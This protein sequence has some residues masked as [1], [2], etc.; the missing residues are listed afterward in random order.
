[1]KLKSQTILCVDDE[2]SNLALLR[3]TLKDSYH[4]VFALNGPEALEAME[5]HHPDLVLLD[6]DMPDMS[7]YEVCRR[8]KAMPATENTPVIFVTACSQEA[9]EAAGF[10][11]G[12]VDYITKPVSTVIVQARVQ[13]HLSLVALPLLEQ[14]YSAAIF[15]LGEAG[16]YHDTDT[17]SHI[18][19]M[20]GYSKA[21]AEAA[22]WSPER[23][24]LLELAAPMHDTGKIGIPDAVLKK[25]G[26]FE[27][28]EWE[29]MKTHCRIGY[30]I[31]SKGAAPVFQLAAEIALYHHEKW[32]G[33]G[34][35]NGISGTEIP[36]SA[37]IVAIADVFDALCVKRPYKEAWPLEQVLATLKQIAGQHLDPNLMQ[38]FMDILPRILEIQR[39]WDSQA[40]SA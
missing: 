15:M 40:R 37:R 11:A 34:Y 17:G 3:Q 28:H 7:G 38:I 13:I 26:S 8:I 23:Q 36:E 29:I 19:R 27:P 4:L 30:D 32:E 12:G 10:E 25:P 22:G 9:D 1:M 16:H 18:W 20:A 33:S 5:K 21:L 39:E 2:P 14:T 6:V 35:P 24:R 31:L